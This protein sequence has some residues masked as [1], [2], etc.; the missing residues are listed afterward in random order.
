M[1]LLLAAILLGET[2]AAADAPPKPPCENYEWSTAREQAAFAATPTEA[3]SGATLDALPAGTTRIALKPLS[4]A[5]L[6]TAPEKA[7]KDGAKG[8]WL[9]LPIAAAGTY[10]ITL[11]G[12]LWVDAVQAGQTTAPK[13]HGGDPSCKLFHKSLRFDLQ[14]GPLTLQFSGEGADSVTFTILPA[15][16]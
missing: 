6:P 12:R 11:D 9:I 1:N 15:A 8:A 5:G 14:A 7:P 16:E 4:E 2:A 13:A 3:T 10:H